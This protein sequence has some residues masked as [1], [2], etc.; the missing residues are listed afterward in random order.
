MFN[1]YKLLVALKNESTHA[2]MNSQKLETFNSVL[3]RGVLVDNSAVKVNW[4]T[5]HPAIVRTD[6]PNIMAH[7]IH[8]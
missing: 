7:M 4:L 8:Y 6:S 3:L 2:R 1:N 5:H